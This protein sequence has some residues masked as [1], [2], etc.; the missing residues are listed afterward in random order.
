[1]LYLLE[2]SEQSVV[3]CV[4]NFWRIQGVISMRVVMQYL[5]KLYCFLTGK[6]EGIERF[7]LVF[8]RI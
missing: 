6:I 7:R 8:R 3:F 1:M 4:W 5:A 2:L